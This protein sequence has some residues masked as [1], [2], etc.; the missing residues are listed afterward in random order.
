M[1]ATT[2]KILVVNS[3]GGSGKTTIAT[4]LAVAF[5]NQGLKVSLLDCDRQASCL[6]W[7][8]ERNVQAP[9]VTTVANYHSAD[10]LTAQIDHELDHGT[11]VIVM[12][13]TGRHTDAALF[14]AALKISDLILIP[15]LSSS[16]DIKAGERF[17]ADLMTHR[18]M[19]ATPKPMGVIYNR[20]NT[21]SANQQRLETLLRC[22]DVPV[23]A[24]LKDSTV[25]ANAA[26]KGAGIMEMRENAAASKE[27]SA[28]RDIM[29][30]IDRR[31]VVRRELP[32]PI[33]A[34]RKTTGS[35]PKQTRVS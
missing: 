29:L 2:K 12:D 18:V 22:L 23:I 14:E 30:W 7:A 20:A 8:E 31:T 32:R 19:R 28:W 21:S 4:N 34:G 10:K 6:H 9:K 1:S 35:N 13:V 5:A 3:K 17:V 24:E 27:Y 15:M 16:L 11:D 25:Y 33:Q 26:E